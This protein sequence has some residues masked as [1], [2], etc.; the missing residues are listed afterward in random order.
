MTTIPRHCL[1][2]FADYKQKD[3]A[4][5]GNINPADSLAAGS[6]VLYGR[7]LPVLYPQAV[8]RIAFGSCLYP[9]PFQKNGALCCKN[10][11]IT[12]KYYV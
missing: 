12:Q 11:Y 2:G 10:F 3:L 6:M 1:V 7:Y 9:Q 4:V 5:N 8:L